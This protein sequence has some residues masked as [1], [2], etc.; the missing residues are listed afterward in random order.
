[1]DDLRVCSSCET[2][3]I[4]ISQVVEKWKIADQMFRSVE[5]EKVIS[6]VEQIEEILEEEMVQEN[7]EDYIVEE[8]ELNRVENVQITEKTALYDFKCHVCSESFNKM[9]E[10]TNH[11]RLKHSCLPKVACECGRYLS[12]WESLQKHQKMHLKQEKTFECDSCDKKF[13]TTTGLRIHKQNS[14]HKTPEELS[15]EICGKLFKDFRILKKHKRTHLPD[16]EKYCF[17]CELCGKR[18]ID[19]FSLKYHIENVHYGVKVAECKICN[20]TFA[21][22][23]NLRSHMIS[24]SNEKIECKSCG[25]IFKNQISLQTHFKNFH[26]ENLKRFTCEQ[27]EKTF[28]SKVELLRHSSRVHAEAYKDQPSE[29]FEIIVYECSTDQ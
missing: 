6:E 2:D 8:T 18:L 1:M 28:K 12:T 10:L 29:E 22:R 13:L 19:K 11:T 17:E 24:H 5:T 9:F 27:C 14:D 25:K 26:K 20:K 4:Q 7:F 16:D 23:S 3:I 21:H 15:C